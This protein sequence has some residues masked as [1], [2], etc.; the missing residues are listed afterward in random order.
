MVGPTGS[1]GRT[2]SRDDGCIARGTSAVAGRTRVR[3]GVGQQ[4]AVPGVG[5]D[6][7]RKTPGP[8]NGEAWI[9]E[10]VESP[11]GGHTGFGYAYSG[12]RYPPLGAPY[13]RSPSA[14]VWG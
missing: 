2:S 10:R 8:R 13:Y 9:V 4:L 1:M 5:G 3:G 7:L 6:R 12:R 14:P 11:L